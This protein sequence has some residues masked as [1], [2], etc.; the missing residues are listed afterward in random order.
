[1]V[2]GLWW[3]DAGAAYIGSRSQRY[4][5]ADDLLVEWTLE[6]AADPHRITIDPDPKSRSGAARIIGYSPSADLILTIIIRPDTHK[7]I[8]AWPTTG[9]ERQ[10]Y[11]KQLGGSRD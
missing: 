5:G 4:S 2:E 1:M 7:G 9:A 10:I 3:D 8:T 6:A 11:L